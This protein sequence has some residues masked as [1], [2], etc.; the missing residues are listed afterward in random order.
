MVPDV[1]DVLCPDLDDLSKW[2]PDGDEVCLW[3]ELSIGLPGQNAADVFQVC[4]ATPA[5][6]KAP[7]GRR[8][9]PRGSAKSPPIVLQEY[10]W[11]ALQEAIRHRLEACAGRDWLEIQEKLRRQFDWEY[12]GYK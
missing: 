11:S 1:K 6:L 9:K 2:R 12:E 7:L 3:L 10:S 8:L 4:V 5:G